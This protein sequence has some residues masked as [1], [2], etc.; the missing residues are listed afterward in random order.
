MNSTST[1]IGGRALVRLLKALARAHAFAEIDLDNPAAPRVRVY[2]GAGAPATFDVTHHPAWDV[3]QRV[4][5]AGFVECDAQSKPERWQISALG[6]ERLKA[7]NNATRPAAYQDHGQRRAGRKERCGARH[8]RPHART[9]PQESSS[10]SPLGW[11]YRRRDKAGETLISRSQFDAGERLRLDYEL[12]QLMPRLTVDWTLASTGGAPHNVGAHRGLEISERALAARERVSQALGAVEPELASLLVDVCCHLKGL[13][14]L[15]KAAGWPQRSAKIV[16]QVALSALARHYGL[17][18]RQR[19][20]G[21]CQAGPARV[22][23]WG[24]EGYR[25]HTIGVGSEADEQGRE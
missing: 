3:W 23:H 18:R 1:A 4:Q 22:L 15:E 25:P 10:E 9:G 21:R 13:E 14:Q 12:A 7:Y 17:E 24:A 6:R 11:L 19:D 20:D 8:E 2:S 16:L 5:N